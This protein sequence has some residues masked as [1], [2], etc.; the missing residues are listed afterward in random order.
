MTVLGR[1]WRRA[2]GCLPP[3]FEPKSWGR[4]AFLLLVVSWWLAPMAYL[5]VEPLHRAYR[6][7]WPDLAARLLLIGIFML[8]SVVMFGVFQWFLVKIFKAPRPGAWKAGPR[9]RR[10][11]R[12]R[13]RQ[14]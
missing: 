12:G 14:R 8:G 7:G 1:A 3:F 5:L 13:R 9:K 6:Q 4:A 2:C 10:S 11:M